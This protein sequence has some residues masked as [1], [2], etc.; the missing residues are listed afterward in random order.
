MKDNALLADDPTE[1]ADEDPLS[2][3][4][5][6]DFALDVGGFLFAEPAEG[7]FAYDA[8]EILEGV[9]GF[10]VIT[11]TCD[12]IRRVDD[13]RDFVA[14][15]PLLERPAEEINAIKKGHRPYLTEVENTP[16]NVFADLGRVMSI[17]KDLLIT[18]ERQEGFSSQGKRL[19]FAAALERKFGRFA[20]PD[21]FDAAVKQF[22]KRV[23][24]RHDKQGSEPGKV[25]RSLVQIR[26]K[27][28]PDWDAERRKITVLA[29]LHD[30][31]D[32]EADS[33]TIRE[34]LE[35]SLARIEL[36]QGYEWDSPN[37]IIAMPKDL[38]AEDLLSSQ[39]A[40]FDYLCA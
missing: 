35:I 15:C 37:L 11:Q 31:G 6:G 34:E 38:T 19:R 7:D 29:L 3:W 5:Q 8:R 30:E 39:R 14:V 17:S 9:V 33:D 4:R 2:H 16:E 27:A 40:D 26:F 22:H 12:I 36:P 20:F 10:I 28:E 13:E 32:R 1:E 23:W 24:A 21:E 18:W 25:Y